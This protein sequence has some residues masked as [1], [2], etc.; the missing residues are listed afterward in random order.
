MN[1]KG[2]KIFIALNIAIIVGILIYQYVIVPRTVVRQSISQ[3]YR[4]YRNQIDRPVK[5]MGPAVVAHH[6]D[7]VQQGSGS[8][9]DSGQRDER[10]ESEKADLREILKVVNGAAKRCEE[11]LKVVFPDYELIDVQNPFYTD[12]ALVREKVR[13]AI[14]KTFAK[15]DHRYLKAFGLFLESNTRFDAHWGYEQ[16]IKIDS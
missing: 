10:L 8:G 9:I 15:E 14:I 2:L 16:L 7:A 12:P 5:R 1:M 6:T 3:R 4:S 11:N 13:E